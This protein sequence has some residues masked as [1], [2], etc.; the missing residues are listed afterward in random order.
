M[1]FSKLSKHELISLCELIYF[2]KMTKEE[3]QEVCN[4]TFNRIKIDEEFAKKT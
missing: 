4:L 1:D 2:S 3:I